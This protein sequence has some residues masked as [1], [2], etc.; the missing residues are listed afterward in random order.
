MNVGIYEAK[1]RLSELLQRV[2]S[3]NEVVITSHGKPVARLIPADP[4]AIPDRPKAVRK[5]RALRR[6]LN[7][8]IRGSIRALVE[9]G[10]D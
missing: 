7:V 4:S 3:G 6:R 9:E 8:R 1:A 5:I 2:R 10:R